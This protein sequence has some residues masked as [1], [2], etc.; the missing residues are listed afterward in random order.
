MRVR[1]ILFTSNVCGASWE[2]WIELNRKWCGN[3]KEIYVSTA[4]IN[5]QKSEKRENE[6]EK[7]IAA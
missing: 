1:C 5:V 2:M 3:F 6:M 7:Q 4:K